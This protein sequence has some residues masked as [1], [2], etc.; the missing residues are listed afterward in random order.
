MD[1][2]TLS[3]A[4]IAAHLVSA[5]ATGAA[6]GGVVYAGILWRQRTQAASI[7]RTEQCVMWM[8]EVLLDVARVH[9]ELHPESPIDVSGMARL[10]FNGNGGESR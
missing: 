7:R 6:A 2:A 9:N 4:G 1:Q 3:V 10:L 5:I 8:A